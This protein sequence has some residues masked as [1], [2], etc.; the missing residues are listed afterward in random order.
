MRTFTKSASAIAAISLALGMG[1]AQAA[2]W[3]FTLTGQVITAD[4]P[5]DY[6]LAFGSPVT[7]VGTFDDSVLTGGTGSISFATPGNTFTVNAGDIEFTPGEV[8]SGTPT[9]SLVSM[10][11]DFV[12]NGFSFDATDTIT[13]ASFT[14]YYSYFDGFDAGFGYMKGNWQEFTVTAV[15]VPAA[16]WLFGSGLLGL[17]GIAR[18]KTAV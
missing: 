14:S 11:I 15:P 1:S 5:N 4:D 6:N 7:V 17:A 13:E 12:N 2:L 3:N 9:L 10:D 18:R 16:A 8:F